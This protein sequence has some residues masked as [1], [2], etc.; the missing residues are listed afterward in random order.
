MS[1]SSL[2]FVEIGQM[3]SSIDLNPVQAALQGPNLP[4]L[5]EFV[6]DKNAVHYA[7]RVGFEGYALQFSDETKGI[8]EL[9]AI[10]KWGAELA[11]MLYTYRS[12]AR[13]LPTVGGDEALKRAMYAS[14]FEVL[15]P[16]MDEIKQLILFK[17]RVVAKWTTNLGLLIRAEARLCASNGDGAAIPC[18]AL[19][20]QLLSTLDTLALIDALKDTKAC[21]NNDFSVYKRA[22]QHCRADLPDAQQKDAENT[23]LQ[24]MLPSRMVMLTALRASVQKLGGYDTV[25]A[26]MA[27]LAIEH[28]ENEWYLLPTEKHRLLRSAAHALW[29]LDSPD[30]G[31]VN[32]FHHQRIKRDRFVKWLRRYPIVPLYGDMF[33]N[34]PSVL[35]RCPNFGTISPTELIAR[36]GREAG[37]RASQYS[38]TAQ[39]PPLRAQAVDLQSEITQLLR[40]IDALGGAERC[41]ASLKSRHAHTELALELLEFTLCGCR[42]MSG[43]AAL[44]HEVLAYKCAHVATDA[45][46]HERARGA[47]WCDY[48]RALRYNLDGAEKSA[49]VELV[50]TLKD[51]ERCLGHVCGS[52][53]RLL[54]RGVHELTQRFIHQTM[55]APTRKA[56]K[57]EKRALKTVLMQLR[58]LSADAGIAKEDIDRLLDEEVIK[59][60]WFKHSENLGYPARAVPPSQTQLWLMRATAR[61]LYDERSPHIKGGMM[62]E[63]PLS[64]EIIKEMSA[65]VSA[66]ACFP[67]LLRLS[68][69]LQELGDVSVLWMREFFL[70]LSQRV[71][72]PISMSLPSILCNHV[73]ANGNSHLLPRLLYTF[74][75]YSDGARRAL[76]THRQQHLLVEIEAETNLVFDHVL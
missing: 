42:L 10:D 35:E 19:Y 13:A 27:T 40:R 5:Y 7:D 26:D 50:A 52:N 20:V 46:M 48:E 59:S 17:E 30:K 61:A 37:A 60:K 28:L 12:I 18:E 25:V 73:L 16:V 45:E 54:C 76:Q 55:G 33:A 70:E 2:D 11:S 75:A 4:L 15:D 9:E 41:E 1:A 72:F 29:L 57:Y 71:Q 44:L 38:I 53:E 6:S 68:S 23:L 14:S 36:T 58:N 32:A 47:E 8:V 74:E 24:Q 51:L 65:F 69:T 66:S 3:L 39:L 49:L 21:L 22:F 62:H 56:V 34:L 43:V 63:A 64:K 31:G 67:Y